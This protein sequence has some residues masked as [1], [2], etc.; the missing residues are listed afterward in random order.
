MFGDILDVEDMHVRGMRYQLL[1]RPMLV[2]G[3]DNSDKV[4]AG[5]N[6]STLLENLEEGL[7]ADIIF[8]E[9]D[10]VDDQQQGFPAKFSHSQGDL[11]HLVQRSFN[12]E[13]R[14]AIPRPPYTEQA[15]D[16]VFVIFEVNGFA[17][18]YAKDLQ[19]VVGLEHGDAVAVD[20]THGFKKK[21][22]L[23]GASL[24]HDEIVSPPGLA[25]Q[26]VVDGLLLGSGH[27]VLPI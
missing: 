22:A 16:V 25:A 20:F 11:F 23:P 2:R 3:E 7:A 13:K 12:V 14:R 9:M 27:P 4:V 26:N 21:R 10:V 5:P 6:L 17:Q 15:A 19:V 18:P 1:K 8:E 24:A